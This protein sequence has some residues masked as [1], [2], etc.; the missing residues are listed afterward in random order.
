[1]RLSDLEHIIRAAAE[2]T[3][4][5]EFIVVGSQSILG[6]VADP[7][8]ECLMSMEADIYPRGAEHL[9]E[10]DWRFAWIRRIYSCPSVMP[11]GQR[12]RNLMPF[13]LRM[14]L[15]NPKSPSIGLKKCR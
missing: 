1:M 3:K 14:A 7:P 2:I 8:Q 5:Y 15:C 12:I 9:S 13:W 4:E 10:I 6:A 11:T